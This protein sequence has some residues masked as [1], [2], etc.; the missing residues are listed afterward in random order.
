MGTVIIVWRADTV[1]MEIVEAR[2][3]LTAETASARFLGR[4]VLAAT[5]LILVWIVLIYRWKAEAVMRWRKTWGGN[6][7]S[8][9]RAIMI[10]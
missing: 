8:R 6:G 2:I 7:G 3:D 5:I 4:K 1:D 10:L 9:C